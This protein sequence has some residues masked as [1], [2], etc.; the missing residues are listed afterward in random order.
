MREQE[1]KEG[2]GEHHC[3]VKVDTAFFCLSSLCFRGGAEEHDE[4]DDQ[5]RLITRSVALLCN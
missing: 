5:G 3:E 4:H 2:A 1:M